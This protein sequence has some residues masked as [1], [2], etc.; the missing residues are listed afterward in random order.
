MSSELYWHLIMGGQR[1]S[2]ILKSVELF[3]WKTGENCQLDALPGEVRGH[4]AV[5]LYESLVVYCGGLDKNSTAV[6]SCYHKQ[7]MKANESWLPV[8]ITE[9]TS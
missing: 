1:G 3:N 5:T 4:A 8:S 2:G 9:Y 6:S 7:Q